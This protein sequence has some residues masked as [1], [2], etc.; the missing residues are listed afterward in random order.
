MNRLF[1]FAGLLLASL[2]APLH[3]QTI[4]DGIMMAGGDLLTGNVYAHDSWDEYWEGALKRDNGN[5][6]TVTTRPTSGTANYGLTDRMNFIAWCRTC[7]PRPAR[8]CSTAS[9]ASRTSRWRRSTASSRRRRRTTARCG[10]SPSV[11]AGIPLTDYNP[12]L[13]PLSIGGGGGRVSWRGTLQLCNR[14][15]AGSSTDRPPTRGAGR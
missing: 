4:E 12:E 7:G 10:P 11:A 15:R 8:A 9:R 13:P 14:R 5:I 2:S 6:G 1:A 3:A